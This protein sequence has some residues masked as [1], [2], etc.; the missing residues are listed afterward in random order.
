MDWR[1]E[2]LQ[3]RQ[4]LKVIRTMNNL[5]KGDSD[6]Y[7]DGEGKRDAIWLKVRITTKESGTWT[8]NT[9]TGTLETGKK[10]LLESPLHGLK[11]KEFTIVALVLLYI[12][13]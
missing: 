3:R 9:G 5:N 11:K 10:W 13:G 7:H 4:E 6:K 1:W 2:L 8:I 12:G